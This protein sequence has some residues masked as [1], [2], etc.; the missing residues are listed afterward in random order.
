MDYRFLL[1]RA[2]KLQDQTY[3][4]SALGKANGV[5]IVR[6]TA[7]VNGEQVMRI[8]PARMAL[9]H[10]LYDEEIELCPVAFA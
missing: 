10:L 1:G 2:F 8:F 9:D 7:R 3:V 6:A 4:A 5:E